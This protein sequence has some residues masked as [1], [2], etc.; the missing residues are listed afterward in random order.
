[1]NLG[2]AVDHVIRKIKREDV[3]TLSQINVFRQEARQFI[4]SMLGN[5]HER[6]P[7][8][9]LFLKS[10]S[11]LDPLVL[12][13]LP[14]EKIKER[15]KSLLKCLIDLGISSPQRCDLATNQFITFL[16]DKMFSVGRILFW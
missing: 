15:W 13:D 1:M 2:F 4:T 5:F 9:S 6:S 14:R 12:H 10:A 11:V 16:S 8:G 3:V 7:L